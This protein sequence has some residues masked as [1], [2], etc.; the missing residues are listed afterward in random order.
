MRQRGV[1]I[2]ALS[3]LAVAVA[4]AQ[5]RREGQLRPGDL[6]PDFTLEPPGGGAPV[7]L[8][9]FR[10]VRPVALVFGSYT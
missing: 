10:G 4:A 8:S 5:D 2:F 7:S 1:L 9:A 6:A 3:L